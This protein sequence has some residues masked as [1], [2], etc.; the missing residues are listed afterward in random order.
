MVTAS[1]T[2]GGVGFRSLMVEQGSFHTIKTL[3][4]HGPKDQGRMSLTIQIAYCWYHLYYGLHY[5]PFQH[6]QPAVSNVPNGW[7][8]ET[9]DFLA[10][11]ELSIH[12]QNMEQI[13][14]RRIQDRCLMADVNQKTN[15]S[16]SQKNTSIIADCIWK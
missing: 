7:I 15:Y 8:S 11:S 13:P 6:G 12:W 10:K 9:Q 3:I 4:S 16:N 14:P 2:A 1:R 5:H